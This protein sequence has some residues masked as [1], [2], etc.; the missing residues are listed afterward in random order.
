MANGQNLTLEQF[1][2][3]FVKTVEGGI[4]RNGYAPVVQVVKAVGGVAH[5]LLQFL[6]PRT[7]DAGGV[8]D[9]AE[10]ERRLNVDV[11]KKLEGSVDGYVVLH[12]I[13]PILNEVRLE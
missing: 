9:V 11:L 10:G 1:G 12:T 6:A 13:A 8:H 7:V 2:G 5:F 3:G 4:R